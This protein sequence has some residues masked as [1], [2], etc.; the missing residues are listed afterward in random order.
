MRYNA[1]AN[2]DVVKRLQEE[3]KKDEL[4]AKALISQGET[5]C[6][7]LEREAERLAKE[8]ERLGGEVEA[9]DE[10]IKEAT[11]KV[12]DAQQKVEDKQRALLEAL[13]VAGGL[14]NE[15]QWLSDGVRGGS[16]SDGALPDGAELPVL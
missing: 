4:R 13:E 9:K 11:Q 8:V 3:A 16:L 15:L 5:R 10:T 7:Q 12:R 14:R 1:K 2:E 6:L